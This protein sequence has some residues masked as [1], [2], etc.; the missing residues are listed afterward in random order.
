M[1]A[2]AYAAFCPMSLGKVYRV[3]RGVPRPG[4]PRY[5]VP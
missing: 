1:K 4:A 3:F 5:C 2:K